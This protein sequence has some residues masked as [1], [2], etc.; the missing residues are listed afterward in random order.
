MSVNEKVFTFDEIKDLGSIVRKGS[1]AV[2]TRLSD[3]APLFRMSQTAYQLVKCPTCG[4]RVHKSEI[5]KPR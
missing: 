4:R 2:A 5:K 1:K 3:R